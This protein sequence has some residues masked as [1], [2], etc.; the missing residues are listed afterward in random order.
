MLFSLT[1]PKEILDILSK[2][3]DI[4]ATKE[5]G[6]KKMQKKINIYA[7]ENR[8]QLDNRDLS[9]FWQLAQ[10]HSSIY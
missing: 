5:S 8:G 1:G 10:C 6:R 3:K 2:I 9:N 4:N 7:R